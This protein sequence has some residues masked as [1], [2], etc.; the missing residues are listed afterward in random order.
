M[1][2]NDGTGKALQKFG[3]QLSKEEKS[4]HEGGE[5]YFADPRLFVMDMDSGA[6]VLIEPNREN[7]DGKTKGRGY[8][9]CAQVQQ[10]I[11]AKFPQ[12][13]VMGR[14]L[15]MAI[16]NFV[17]KDTDPSHYSVVVERA[18]K[19]IAAALTDDAKWNVEDE[20]HAPALNKAI[21]E[22]MDMT[23]ST[24]AGDTLINVTITPVETAMMDT[25]NILRQKKHVIEWQKEVNANA[26]E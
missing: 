7:E 10:R 12:K 24:R 8:R 13:K 14:L 18:I 19:D 20:K 25:S 15:S 2:W 22:L 16:R 11:P 3:A 21:S 4:R 23:L 1:E 9:R 17:P 26:N 5:D 6:A